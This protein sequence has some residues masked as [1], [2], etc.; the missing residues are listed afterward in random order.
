M[1]APRFQSVQMTQVSGGL[2][3]AQLPGP[4]CGALYEVYFAATTVDC[5][6]LFEPMAGPAGPLSSEVG[7]Q[8][9]S[10]ADNFQTDL[11]WL[12]E[13]LGA[14]SG[15]W[16]RGV[17]VNDPNWAYDPASD[18]D[19]SGSCYMTQNTTGNTDVDNGAVRLTS[20]AFTLGQSTS[21]HFDYY[22]RLTASNSLDQLLVEMS[23]NGQS[24]PW[25]VVEDLRTDGGLDWRGVEIEPAEWSAAGLVT[26]SDARMRFTALDAD[27]QSI[28]EAGIDG[29]VVADVSC[30][31]PGDL[32]TIYCDPAV[33]HSGGVSATI[34]GFG[35]TLIG[36]NDVTL[37]AENLPINQFGY[38]ILGTE[39]A[40]LPGV[41]NSQGVLCLGGNLGRL[42]WA[43][44][45]FSS[46]ALG[47][48]QLSLDLNLLP[49]NPPG[50]VTS[51]ETLHFQCWFRDLNPSSTSNFT[52]A[53]SVTFQ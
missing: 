14:T 2:H 27:G 6:L 3:S 28:V 1:A 23:S 9:Q 41:G 11:G 30:G 8:A 4:S 25:F 49:L 21:V 36:D 18:G 46:G 16:Q 34:R 48:G 44:Q 51:G 35:S 20:P 10:F 17:P 50:P 19:G 29:F 37:F 52:S 32:T 47:E 45:I 39:Q 53:L 22:L 13:N 33:V 26:S 15:D 42:N 38:F 24:G 12:A 5:G 43:G 40:F 7:M 31:R